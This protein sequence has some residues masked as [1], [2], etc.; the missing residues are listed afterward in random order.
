MHII[1]GH[2]LLDILKKNGIQPYNEIVLD[3]S[4]TL[5]TKSWIIGEFSMAF[6]NDL[7]VYGL[8]NYIPEKNDCDNFALHCHSFALKLHT[9][10]QQSY[11]KGFAIGQ[12]VYDKDSG[13]RH[14][15]NFWVIIN[16]VSNK[17]EVV[18]YE[19][20]SRRIVELSEQEK[21]LCFLAL[22]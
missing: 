14:A 7:S 1:S 3:A 19:P 8:L 18:F 17:Y 4:Y 16:P 15:I 11:Q 9:R 13:G 2:T 21:S 6:E 5:P 10:D 22:F 12:F 20:Q